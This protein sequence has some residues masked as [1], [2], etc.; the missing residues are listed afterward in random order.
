MD[1]NHYSAVA[2]ALRPDTG[3]DVQ[4]ATEALNT[5][6]VSDSGRLD[7]QMNVN[8]H[9]SPELP[10]IEMQ[11][12]PRRQRTRHKGSTHG[13]SRH[14]TTK[15]KHQCHLCD[16]SFTVLKDLERHNSTVHPRLGFLC[17]NCNETYSRKKALKRHLKTRHACRESQLF[18]YSQVCSDLPESEGK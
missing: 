10:D 9:H 14:L 7:V 6:T 5:L 13:G 2:N 15:G 4:R 11:V 12:P 3:I 1:A 18:I 17:S 8:L 16:A